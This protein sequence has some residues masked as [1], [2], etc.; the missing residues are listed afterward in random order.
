MSFSKAISLAIFKK[1]AFELKNEELLS[2]ATVIRVKNFFFARI[3]LYFRKQKYF[4][5]RL[6]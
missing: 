1:S 2:T 4:F 3:I 6:W 5:N